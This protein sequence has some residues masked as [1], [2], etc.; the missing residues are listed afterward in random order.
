MPKYLRTI[1]KVMDKIELYVIGISTC[2]FALLMLVNV[3]LRNVFNGGIAWA[4]EMSSYLNI[5]G[6]YLAISAGFKFGDHVGVEAFVDYAIPKKL[7]K[8]FHALSNLICIIFCGGVA[9]Y[10]FKMVLNSIMTKQVSL[11]LHFPIWIV[12]SFIMVGMIASV[13]RLIM[14]IVKIYY[15][16]GEGGAEL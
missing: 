6:V 16:G 3:I 14:N 4:N 9:Y 8:H 13:I 2:A 7:R 5:L 10:S 11:V 12:Y 15:K 1:D